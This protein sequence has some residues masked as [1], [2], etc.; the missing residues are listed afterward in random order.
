MTTITSRT[1]L[2][3]LNRYTLLPPETA[4][5]TLQDGRVLPSQQYALSFVSKY[6]Q[7]KLLARDF[8]TY[9]EYD[10]LQ[11][12]M[13]YA[14]WVASLSYLKAE[15]FDKPF[16]QYLAACLKR[17]LFRLHQWRVKRDIIWSDIPSV[18]AILDAQDTLDDQSEVRHSSMTTR[19]ATSAAL[20]LAD[21]FER[22]AS[23]EA[24]HRFLLTLTPRQALIVRYR[25]ENDDQSMVETARE[26]NINLRTLFRDLA[27]IQS[28]FVQYVTTT[29]RSW[30]HYLRRLY[31]RA[32]DNE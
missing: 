31:R 16:R 4:Q 5:V 22:I 9:L 2:R 6:C 11:A 26:L 14:L 27:A 3:Q 1:L 7:P 8:G 13:L 24:V 23:Y 20:L 30:M 32:S 10:D 18:D 29:E 15:K 12:E 17:R 28:Q 21:D 25:M 19:A